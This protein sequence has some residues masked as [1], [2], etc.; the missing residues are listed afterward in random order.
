MRRT[1]L[2]FAAASCLAAPA[3]AGPAE[4]AM[5]AADTAFND[6]AQKDGIAAAFEAYAAPDA[7]MFRGEEKIVSGPAEVRELMAA[8]YAQ[9]GTL[10]W[11][12]V[13]AVASADGTMGFTHGRW[14]Y[15]SPK[16]ED[17][18]TRKSAGSYVTIWALQPDGGY[19]FSLDIGSP[20]RPQ[21]S[22]D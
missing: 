12:P 15:E 3:L 9:G 4:D 14:A 5:I 11:A 7:R 21:E 18:T 17:G 1:L 6:L 19:K 13:E 2:A 10:T 22:G 8:Q 20:D 16:L